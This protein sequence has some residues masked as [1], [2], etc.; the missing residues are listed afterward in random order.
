VVN[1]AKSTATK[2]FEYMPFVF[3]DFSNEEIHRYTLHLKSIIKSAINL[4][5][6]KNLINGK[7]PT[8][9]DCHSNAQNFSDENPLYDCVRGWLVIDGGTYS[10][11]IILLPHSAV[12][13]DV[14]NIFEITPIKSLDP[15]P[16]LESD[17]SEEDFCNLHSTLVSTQHAIRLVI[18]K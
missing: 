5:F 7:E 15:R 2:N 9:N 6:R 12:K 18:N 11:Q 4:P 13:D 17:L 10:P 3:N 1:A 16:F 8:P 14:G